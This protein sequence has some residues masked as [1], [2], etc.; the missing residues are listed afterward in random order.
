MKNYLK[1]LEFQKRLTSLSTF[2]SRIGTLD[3]T[4]YKT[5]LKEIYE[6]SSFLS[7]NISDKYVPFANFAEYVKV[8]DYDL[9]IKE[10]WDK[11]IQLKVD[12]NLID[13]LKGKTLKVF[14]Q[15]IVKCNECTTGKK[16][17]EDKCSVCHGS[18]IKRK[19]A[20]NCLCHSCKGY[21]YHTNQKCST[22]HNNL[23]YKKRNSI[24]LKIDKDFYE[25][26][27]F[28]FS[29]LG[30]YDIFNNNYGSLKIKPVLVSDVVY[31]NNRRIDLKVVNGSQVES[32]EKVKLT[33]M[34]LGGAHD[35][36]HALGKCTI[37][38]E[39]STQPGDYKVI[40]NIGI[41]KLLRPCRI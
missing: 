11:N 27:I 13:A 18:G 21:G 22:C 39:P 26:C 37:I 17:T 2:I 25:G 33:T 14:Y 34:V 30:N 20:N 40:N 15:Q 4:L 24:D 7:E 41:P 10:N 16:N 1:K 28:S 32:E 9:K 38:I 12:V 5:R 31:D 29:S 8:F 6:K 35:V 36:N 3:R 19:E 23:V